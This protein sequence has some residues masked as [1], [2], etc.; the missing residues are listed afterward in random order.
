MPITHR[1][2]LARRWA[3]ALLAVAVLA[4]PLAATPA[5]VAVL[6]TAAWSPG[7]TV[8][9]GAGEFEVFVCAASLRRDHPTAGLVGVGDRHGM[10]LQG[11]ERAL[12]LLALKGVPVAKIA[13]GG[14]FAADPDEIFLNASG[15][16]EADAASLLKKCLERH[17]APPA[18]ANPARPTAVELAA[19][20]AHLR[21]FRDAFA[22]ASAPHLASR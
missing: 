17:G 21:P 8:R 15:L 18:A 1:S 16:S 22:V 20:R 11:A 14:D 19:I 12:R 9:E 13:R 3:G 6:R 7:D 5:G 10:F 4:S 2:L